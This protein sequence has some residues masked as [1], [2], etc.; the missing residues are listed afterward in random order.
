MKDYLTNGA[1]QLNLKECEMLFGKVSLVE[2]RF[3]KN[4]YEEFEILLK[5]LNEGE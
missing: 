4:H 1:G 3:F 5:W 2:D